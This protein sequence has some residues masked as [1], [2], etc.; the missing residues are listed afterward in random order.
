MK[1]LALDIST[2]TGY[3]LLEHISEGEVP[4]ILERGNITP[5]E[6][7]TEAGEYPWNYITVASDMG[8]Q[9]MQ[10][11]YDT[12]PDVI[13]VEETNIARSR[14]SQKILEF[15]HCSFLSLLEVTDY[16]IKYVSTSDWRAACDVFMS[17]DDKKNNAKVNKA[18]RDGKS[19]KEVGLKG[20]ITR[21]HIAI[22]RI[23][24]LYGLDL[25]QKE[26]DIA[27]AILLGVSYTRG[28]K[29][30]IGIEGKS[31]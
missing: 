11:V 15:I 23:K 22:R 2:R 25:K 14:Y 4:Q 24:E 17:K 16:D 30:S 8:N 3:A 31:K 18:K 1:I 6:T 19:K 21:K 27:E 29:I 7:L 28:V 5:H 10:K 26:N 12:D 9:L 13:I 20:K